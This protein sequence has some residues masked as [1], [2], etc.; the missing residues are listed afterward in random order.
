MAIIVPTTTPII[1]QRGVVLNVRSIYNPVIKNP[2]VGINIRQVVSANVM[3]IKIAVEFFGGSFV[4]LSRIF[5]KSAM[6]L[7]TI[8]TIMPRRNKYPANPTDKLK[9]LK[10]GQKRQFR[11]QNEAEQVAYDQMLLRPDLD[12]SVYKCDYCRGWHLTRLKNAE[13]ER[14]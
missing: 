8:T 14:R 10:H 12:L 11:N 3:S 13:S 5:G 4:S 1:I 9:V 2:T 7:Y 6:Y